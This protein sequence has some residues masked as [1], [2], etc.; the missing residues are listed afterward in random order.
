MTSFIGNHKVTYTLRTFSRYTSKYLQLS[1]WSFSSHQASKC[2]REV[3]K[4]RKEE[5]LTQEGEKL[6]GTKPSVSALRTP[7]QMRRV[8]SHPW[9]WGIKRVFFRDEFEP[10]KVF[11]SEEPKQ[12]RLWFCL[13]KKRRIGISNLEQTQWLN[14]KV[15]FV[16]F[17]SRLL[18]CN[19]IRFIFSQA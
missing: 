17:V 8:A 15:I 3:V 11:I 4:N 13:I 12:Y 2:E 9:I 19:P 5:R 6:H 16:F 10:L 14:F 18:R 7:T 1:M